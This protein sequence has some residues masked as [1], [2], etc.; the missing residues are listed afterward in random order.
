MTSLIKNI[1]L[2]IS[3]LFAAV[4]CQSQPG[5]DVATKQLTLTGQV[6]Q[7]TTLA[8]NKAVSGDNNNT[9]NIEF[10]AENNTYRG[11]AG[12][13]NYS[14][15]YMAKAEKLELG[16][17]RA[18]RKYCA[19]SS[20]QESVLFK[21]MAAVSTYRIDNKTFTLKDDLNQVLA[22]FIAVATK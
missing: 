17:A 6:W 7:L 10:L 19:Q 2:S 12:C 18:T 20:T 22:V 11:F 5:A 16:P 4:G 14:G 13:N 15:S 21:A 8:G 1:G 9:V 3:L